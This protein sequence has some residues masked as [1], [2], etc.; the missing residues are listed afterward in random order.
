MD[1][2]VDI[3][4]ISRTREL[5]LDDPPET[6]QIRALDEEGNL[7][8]CWSS[9]KRCLHHV[10]NNTLLTQLSYVQHFCILYVYYVF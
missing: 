9:Y 1:R 10:I 3:D 7:I 5:Y 6:L 2:I 8:F 4:I